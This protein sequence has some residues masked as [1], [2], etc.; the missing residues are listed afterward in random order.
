M[1]RSLF[2][3]VPFACG[4]AAPN[5]F[6]LAPLT[7]GQSH[8]DGTLGDDERRW[9]VR[10][11]AGGFGL[12]STCAAHVSE[13]GKGFDGQ[14]GV[15]G[16]Q[17]LP[18]LTTLASELRAQGAVA[19]A[20]LYHGGARCPSRLTGA[21]PWSASA[22]TENK[23][24]FEVPR[25]ATEEDIARVIR[26]FGDA[27]ARCAKAGFDGV[28]LHGAHGYLLSQFLSATMN[29]RADAWG[30]SLENRAR[31]LREVTR[32]ARARGGERFVVGV[33]LS[34]E[35]FGFTR[36]VDL[37][38]TVQV[39]RWLADDSAD[40]V[41]LS[42]WDVNRMTKKR[43]AEHPITVFRAA[44]P[45]HVRIVVA[46]KV[47]TRADAERCLSLGADLVAFGRAAIVN[48]DLPTRCGDEAWSPRRPPLTPAEYAERDVSPAFVGYLRRFE[49]MVAG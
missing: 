4:A 28:E 41:H 44:L 15:W 38:E 31:L 47:W 1:T 11:A 10:R 45:E 49:G 22:F 2:A 21:Q 9:L 43:P 32:A 29:T 8:D 39:A 37:D 6:A 19:V 26:H 23:P 46:G 18:G 3:P 13:D 40:F 27:A 25:A 34:P 7:N 48:P 14:L 20:Q 12:V 36:G 5:A 16:D 30:A 17:H 35:D 42:L 24:D 33:R